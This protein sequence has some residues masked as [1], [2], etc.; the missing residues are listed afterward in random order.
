MARSWYN[1][2]PCSLVSVVGESLTEL[3]VSLLGLPGALDR[4][5]LLQAPGTKLVPCVDPGLW[6]KRE[7]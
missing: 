3:G 6:H 7:Q 5:G 4:T 2:A 1:P